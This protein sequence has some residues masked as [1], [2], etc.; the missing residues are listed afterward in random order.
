MQLLV[1]ALPALA[2]FL[3]DN[4]KGEQTIDFADS[5]AVV[6]LNQALL[7]HYYGVDSWQIPQGYLCPPIPGR[8]DYIHY[9]ADLLKK[10]QLDQGSVRVLDIGTG[11]NLIYS[12]LGAAQYQWKMTA[13]DIDNAALASAADILTA[14]PQLSADIELRHQPDGQA[15][16]ANIIKPGEQYA[17]SVCNPPF[18]Q[19]A[20]EARQKT[21]VNYVI[22]PA[23]SRSA[24]N[25]L[26]WTKPWMKKLWLKNPV[27]QILG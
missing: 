15:I 25:L 4:P 12:L 17:L 1:Q 16:F 6:C 11:A 13:T 19:S 14:N 8:A 18:Y 22:F 20:A 24:S 27:G 9:A 3:Q 23:I 2:D 10:Y 5:R 7:K 26:R 21:S